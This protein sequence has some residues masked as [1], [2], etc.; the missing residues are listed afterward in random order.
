[1]YH[2]TIFL[3]N[4]FLRMLFFSNFLLIEIIVNEGYT[5]RPPGKHNN[6]NKH[7]HKRYE[8]DCESD[9]LNNRTDSLSNINQKLV[10]S[11]SPPTETRTYKCRFYILT[12]FS[13]T[14]FMQYCSWNAFGP[15]S[16]TCMK[17]FDWSESEIA[18]MASLDPITYIFTIY[19]FSWMMDVKGKYRTPNTKSDFPRLL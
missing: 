8:V 18:F 5:E 1:M 15:I 14:A 19:F 6:A 12:I 13:L 17:V 7:C 9:T 2:A 4:L 16:S 3:Q 10:D 11:P